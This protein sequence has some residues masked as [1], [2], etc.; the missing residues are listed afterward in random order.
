[1][2]KTN[3]KEIQSLRESLKN[4]LNLLHFTIDSE[5]KEILFELHFGREPGTKLSNLKNAISVD[6]K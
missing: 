4:A 5:I 3:L 1:M 6:S 2:M